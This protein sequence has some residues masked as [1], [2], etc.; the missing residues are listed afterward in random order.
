MEAENQT[1]E[2]FN[3]PFFIMGGICSYTNWALPEYGGKTFVACSDHLFDTKGYW[4]FYE[5]V[6][7]GTALE[8]Q[9][10]N[11]FVWAK[12]KIASN[13]WEAARQPYEDPNLPSTQAYSSRTGVTNTFPVHT[14]RMAQAVRMHCTAN[15]AVSITVSNKQ[16]STYTED[17]R[18]W[19][20][21]NAYSAVIPV[22]TTSTISFTPD[23]T[24][25]YNLVFNAAGGN[26]AVIRSANVSLGIDV[27]NFATFS[28]YGSAEI[29]YLNVPSSATNFTVSLKPRQNIEMLRVNIYDAANTLVQWGE[30]RTNSMSITN[31]SVSASGRTR[32]MWKVEMVPASTGAGGDVDLK[33]SGDVAP[34]LSLHTNAVWKIARAPVLA[35]VNQTNNAGSTLTYTIPATDDDVLTYSLIG[36]PAGASIDAGTGVFTWTPPLTQVPGDYTVTVR[37]T[38]NGTPP[39]STDQTFTVTVKAPGL[40]LLFR[41]N[42]VNGTT[43]QDESGSNR[44]GTAINNPTLV[45][46]ISSNAL[47]FNAMT[48]Y[49]ETIAFANPTNAITAACWAKSDTPTWNETGVLISKRNAFLLYP[50]KGSKIVNFYTFLN[51]AWVY[52]RFTAPAS[53]DIQQ[54]HHYAG[55]YDIATKDL[56][57]FVDGK[58]AATTNLT[59]AYTIAGD[60]AGKL[61]VGWDDGQAGRYF[62]GSI[63]EVRL[64]DRA[65]S[66]A[67][68]GQLVAQSAESLS[69]GWSTT[70]IG[71]EVKGFVVQSNTLF[72]VCGSGDGFGTGTSDRFCFVPQGSVGDCSINARVVSVQNTTTNAR[73]GVMIRNSL[74][75][76]SMQA[77]LVLTPGSN[78]VFSCRTNTV[79]SCITATVANCPPPQWLKVNRAGDVFSAYRSTDGTT[80]TQVGA[81]QTISMGAA[82]C[83]G[84]L[85]TSLTNGVLCNGMIDNVTVTP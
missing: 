76:D 4:I 64:Y 36:A 84:L 14:L 63:D 61:Y 66:A 52:V 73:A 39:L 8:T 69:S 41:L 18:A 67:E 34:V 47:Q 10:T 70:N 62:N 54:W 38:D 82:T 19:V 26:S 43:V 81:D 42:T 13:E 7:R 3:R 48:Q 58:E 51:S 40:G 30:T 25:V 20:L 79:G 55:T 2:E 23:Q 85:T 6:T 49:V 74:D 45:P 28:R 16:I 33:I 1:A 56:K 9:W 37:V 27:A 77:S 68:I 53:F 12:N 60:S 44:T 83:I 5:G 72:Q 65:L 75:A 80:W 46:G 11:W 32:G 35:T 50:T 59:T 29:F 57:I 22:G 31:I 15:E 24:G 17:V 21:E 78:I 71:Y